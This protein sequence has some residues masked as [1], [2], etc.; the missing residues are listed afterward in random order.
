MLKMAALCGSEGRAPACQRARCL[1]TRGQTR[2]AAGAAP[3]SSRA[4]AGS[5]GRHPLPAALEAAPAQAFPNRSLTSTCLG[6]CMNTTERDAHG[7][8]RLLRLL[9]FWWRA[10]GQNTARCCGVL[11]HGSRRACLAR[12]V[13]GAVQQQGRQVSKVGAQNGASLAGKS[14]H[15]RQRLFSGFHVTRCRCLPHCLHHL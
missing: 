13:T 2:S 14:L 7:L 10:R 1:M 15:G 11:E 12:R 3:G 9:R 6:G 4:L 5:P 8:L